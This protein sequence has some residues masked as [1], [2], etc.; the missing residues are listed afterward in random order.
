MVMA[1]CGYTA[2]T[3][4]VVVVVVVVV[5]IIISKILQFSFSTNIFINVYAAWQYG[6]L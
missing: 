4:I 1:G 3:Y 5:I 6:F 2:I